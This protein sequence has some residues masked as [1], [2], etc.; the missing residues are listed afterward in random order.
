MKMQLKSN[1]IVM[2]KK[3][4]WDFFLPFLLHLKIQ[5]KN[6]LKSTSKFAKL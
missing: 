4:K 5:E 6:N 1:S 2:R 3:K